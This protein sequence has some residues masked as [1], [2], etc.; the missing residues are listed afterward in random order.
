MRRSLH[1]TT[2]IS[3]VLLVG[4]ALILPPFVLYGSPA[5]SPTASTDLSQIGSVG[6]MQAWLENLEGEALRA[7]KEGR[8]TFDFQEQ[9]LKKAGESIS[10]ILE[11]EKRARLSDPKVSKAFRAAFKKNDEILQFVIGSNEEVIDTLQ[12]E[13][14]DQVE[15]TQ[16][17][18]ES[19]DWQMPHRLISL[20]R[21]WMSWSG[22]YRSFLYPS[23]SAQKKKL[24]DEAVAGFSL[25]LFDI[26]EQ[27]IVAK[28]LF[29][30]ALCFKELGNDEKA[31][32][33]LEAITKHVRQNDPL[34][35]W[36]LY[37][38]AR[39]RYKAGDH[40]GAL[41]HLEE[42]ETEI[43]EKTLTDVLGNEHKRLREKAALE[44][45]AKVLLAKIDKETD[46]SGE[47]AR[48]L[49]REALEVLKR[50]SRYDPDYATKLYRLVEEN[51][52]FFSQLSYEDLGAIGYLALADDR[53][54]KG[55]FAEAAKRYRQL[56]T[57]SDIYIRNRMDDVY[58]RSGYA[59]CQI[60][61]WK[62]AL[63]SFD[64]LYAKFPRSGLV[65]KAVCLEYVAAAGNYKQA[66]N[67]SNYVRYVESSKKYLKKCPNPRDKDGAH[68]LVGKDYEKQKKSK[69]ARREF[70]AIEEGSPQYWPARYYI[71]KSDVEGL[72][73]LREAGKNGGAD[74]RRRYAATASQFD[75]FQRLP[76]ARKAKPEIAQIWPHM[77]ILQARLFHAGP[78][79][80][81]EEVIQALEGFEK[82]FP[83]NKPL[84]LT[85]MNLRLECYRDKQRI[86]PAITSIRSLLQGYPVDQDLWDL[87]AEWAEAYDEEAERWNK[88][89]NPDRAGAWMELAL[90]VYTGMADIAA[91][92]AG[93]QEYL[94]VIQFRMAE[95]LLAQGETDRAGRIYR[96]ILTRTPDAAD[97]LSNLGRIYEKQG[98]WDQA[99]E[100]WRTYSKGIGEGSAAWL[101]ARY[102]IALAHSKMGRKQAAC[103]VITM[104]R[105]LHPDVEDEGL[106]K[107]ILS[108]EKAVC[109]K[110][111]Q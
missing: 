55:E 32:K 23:D 16:A 40:K 94:D 107:K 38:Q 39:L 68:F 96:Q 64:Q 7:K 21:Y 65:G 30:R 73:R 41:G 54:K 17:F 110:G 37:E 10:R 58:F 52:P 77:T 56:W 33:D 6:A 105:V 27:T 11:L 63:A 78:G 24:L 76:K 19:P 1:G 61:H 100:M 108:L 80:G 8:F 87:L 49:C 31:A 66:S 71:L 101:D 34:Y 92:R 44:P 79:N 12:E 84:W 86:D 83:K 51:P 106:L 97:A 75:K 62:E 85:A 95:I 72:E 48:G 2:R 42:L 109:G 82:R 35:M 3:L 104:I 57:S 26:A 28:S 5:S 99:L 60:G 103:E 88:A 102:R 90:T 98:N 89:G 91:K 69:E 13:K 74:A 36:S 93:Y 29:G 81:C 20:S 67:R 45:R 25:T 18:L 59:Y 9:I 4:I 111:D 15:D 70:S 14:L 50:L 46:K 22:Y 43:E 53:F 47:V